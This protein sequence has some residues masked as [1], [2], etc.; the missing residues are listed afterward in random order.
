MPSFDAA[1]ARLTKPRLQV[2]FGRHSKTH[3][4]VFSQAYPSELKDVNRL[5][6]CSYLFH[7]NRP[8]YCLIH[9]RI[10]GD[11]GHC[12]ECPC[13]AVI[14]KGYGVLELTTFRSGDIRKAALSISLPNVKAP[15]TS[16]HRS[17]ISVW[18][19][20]VR[21]PLTSIPDVIGKGT[22]A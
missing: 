6:P 16:L 1:A 8:K 11:R 2:G 22:N 15:A 18:S 3:L 20:R 12:A 9:C 17:A 19:A 14:V 21:R 10:M 5:V 13:F 4:I 7:E